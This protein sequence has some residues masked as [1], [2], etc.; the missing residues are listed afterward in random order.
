M[1][2]RMLTMREVAEMLHVSRATAYRIARHLPTVRV[3]R[4]L[5]VSS[6]VLAEQLRRYGGELPTGPVREG[7][8]CDDC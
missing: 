2:T 3:G 1:T 4:C 6:D 8:D 7:G 5:R